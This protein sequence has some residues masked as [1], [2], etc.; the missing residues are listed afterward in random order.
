MKILGI[1]TAAATA[2]AALLDDEHL[3]GEFTLCNRMTHSQ[4]LLPMMDQ[5]RQ[6]GGLE[7]SDVDA[8]AVSAGPGSFT[9][10][11]IGS[12][13]AK[14]LGLAWDRPLI[15]VS[16]LAAMAYQLMA[17]HVLICPMMDARR[18][19]VFAGMYAFDPA[20]E[21]LAAPCAMEAG[22]LVELAGKTALERGLEKVIFLGD[23]TLT[24]APFYGR[25]AAAFIQAPPHLSRQRAGAV[26]ALG[27][28]FMK[29]QNPV[30]I[31]GG[32]LQTAAQ[33]AP[34]YLKVSQAERERAARG[35]R[36]AKPGIGDPFKKEKPHEE[37]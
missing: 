22:E 31:E 2:S 1:E 23:G 15:P 26:A 8:I 20:F 11:R 28:H 17:E 37:H 30:G 9:G 21:Q 18:G 24:A 27:L 19:T 12:A 36:A 13:T 4:T 14:G 7:L 3:L 16:T 34:V 33:H 32:S 29:T 10:L 5:L 35:G 6:L 25:C